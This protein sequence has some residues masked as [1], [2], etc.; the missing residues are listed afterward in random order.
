MN[1]AEQH[2]GLPPVTVTDWF[3][4]KHTSTLLG[5]AFIVF[6]VDFMESTSIAKAM[7][8]AKNY[9]ISVPQEILAMGVA[10]L[11]GA[12]FSSYTTT[13]SFS[14]SAVSADIGAKRQLQGTITGS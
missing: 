1:S 11:L 8:R 4:M 2:A 12:M 14:R 3:P 13:G 5:T 6:I 10:N 7:A 9:E